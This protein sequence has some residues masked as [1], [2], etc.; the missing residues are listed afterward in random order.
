MS[1]NQQPKKSTKTKAKTRK[2]KVDALA[3][4]EG[5]GAMYVKIEGDKVTDVKFRIYEPPRFFEAFLRGRRFTEAP[6]ITARICGICPIAYQMSACHAMEMACGVKV[7]GQL[8]ELRRL[9]YCGEWI[10]SHVLHVYMLHLPDFLGYESAL[11][12]APDFPNE[13]NRALRMK[14]LGNDLIDTVVG[15]A[16]HPINVRVGGF[17]RVPTKDEL[18]PLLERLKRGI[19]DCVDT[20]RLMGKLE[21][22]DFDRDYESV[23]VCHPKEYPFNEGRIKSNK[24]LD[25]DVKEFLEHMI[26]EHVPH[27]TSLHSKINGERLYLVGPN[28]RYNLNYDKL[29]PQCKEMAKEIGLGPVCNNQFKTIMVRSI[30]TLYAYEE[31][32]RIIEQY[33]APDRP[34]VDVVPANGPGV[35]HGCTE[36]PRGSLYHRYEI[37][38][39]GVILDAHICPP[40]AQNQPIIESDL[41]HFVHMNKSLPDSKLQWQCEQAIRNYDPCISCSTHFLKLTVDRS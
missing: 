24:G 9:I 5:E 40:T 38:K 36:A 2:I 16:T 22:P 35:G 6:D 41:Y 13:V 34:C 10:E 29:T 12:L 30:E 31:A 28:A 26:E 11:H 20:I 8:R 4:V 18:S 37:D 17:Y 7:E 23:S 19:T 3:R 14:K 27:S 39:N 21:Y 1:A 15:R 32:I 25:I 33:K